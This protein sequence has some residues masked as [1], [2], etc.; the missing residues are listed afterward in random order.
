MQ[1]VRQV[2]HHMPRRVSLCVRPKC[3]TP[4]HIVLFVHHLPP[5]AATC[6]Q[7]VIAAEGAP[8]VG[9]Q[10]PNGVGPRAGGTGSPAHSVVAAYGAPSVDSTPRTARAHW[11]GGQ[12]VLPRGGGKLACAGGGGGVGAPFPDP[13]PSLAP[14]TGP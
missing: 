5:H 12:G 7:S 6:A 10:P 2:V 9:W 1:G 4:L 14:V 11:L 8:A 13:P 3:S